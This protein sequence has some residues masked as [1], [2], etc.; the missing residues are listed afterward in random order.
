MSG[1]HSGPAVHLF[2]SDLPILT[3]ALK[4]PIS[5]RHSFYG[6]IMPHRSAPSLKL[7]QMCF[8][9]DLSHNRRVWIAQFGP[10]RLLPQNCIYFPVA[11][12][13]ASNRRIWRGFAKCKV[14]MRNSPNLVTLKPAMCALFPIIN[15]AEIRP[16]SPAIN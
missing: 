10:D 12:F 3:F 9:S 15:K 11:F 13:N 6:A 4:S 1:I 8:E 2:P 16:R 14:V 5:G 7:P